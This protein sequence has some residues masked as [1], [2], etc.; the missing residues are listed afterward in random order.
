MIQTDLVSDYPDYAAL[1]EE[2]EGTAGLDLFIGDKA[3][4]G[5]GLGTELINTFV[6][7]IVFARPETTACAAD[8]DVRNT[9]SLRAFEKAGF[10]SVREFVDPED[11]ELHTLVRRERD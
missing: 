4:T 2:G 1:I 10:Q 7:E 6:H 11:N 3:Q 8:P 5:R 9:A